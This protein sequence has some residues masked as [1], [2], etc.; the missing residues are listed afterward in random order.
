MFK[1]FPRRSALVLVA[2]LGGSL[3]FGHTAQP[4]GHAGFVTIRG[5]EFIAPN[6]SS[7]LLKGNQP[8]QL[9]RARRLHVRLFE[10]SRSLA[11]STDLQGAGRD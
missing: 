9:A 11:N 5:R 2:L 3:G 8:W 1:L 4:S 6:G 7:L 10:G